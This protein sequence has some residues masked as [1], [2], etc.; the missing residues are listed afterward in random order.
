M[1]CE[2][3]HQSFDVFLTD[4][5]SVNDT[6]EF[7]SHIEHCRDCFDDLEVYYMVKA[8]TGELPEKE[9]ESYDLTKLLSDKLEERRK[10]VRRRRWMR[11]VLALGA[12]LSLI[13]AAYFIFRLF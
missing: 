12:A 8:A 6:E 10:Y 2:E 4:R 9:L 11:M 3:V 1:N 7:I 5:M 13:F